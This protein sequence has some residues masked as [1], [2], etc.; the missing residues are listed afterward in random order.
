MIPLLDSGHIYIQANVKYDDTDSYDFKL[1]GEYTKFRDQG[2]LIGI[3]EQ[4]Q[5]QKVIVT[6]KDLYHQMLTHPAMAP[7]RT[8][9]V[10]EPRSLPYTDKDVE[11][12]FL[13]QD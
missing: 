1:A 10:L 9:L 7:L 11:F 8:K 4:K 2:A 12:T 6:Q 3:I 5:I 13:P